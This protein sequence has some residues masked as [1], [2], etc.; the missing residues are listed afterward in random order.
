[1]ALFGRRPPERVDDLGIPAS[2]NLHSSGSASPQTRAKRLL[3]SNSM[4][5]DQAAINARFD[6]RR[7]VMKPTPAKPK[8]SMAQVEGSGT[9]AT[10]LMVTFQ[11]PTTTGS[12]KAT[13]CPD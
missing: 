8:I 4:I 7:Y 12:S 5:A 9:S 13:I 2:E 6:L 10:V 1:L 11:L 3:N